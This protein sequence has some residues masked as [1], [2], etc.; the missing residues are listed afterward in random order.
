MNTPDISAANE[1]TKH[2]Q[3]YEY[4]HKAIVQ[5]RYKNGERLPSEVDLAKKFKTSRPTVARSLSD[6]HQSGL[7][8]RKVGSGTYVKF[9]GE[10]CG[11]KTFGLMVPGLGETEIFEPITAYM[12]YIAEKN[13]L[14]LL[15]G[16]SVSE[17][18]EA[19]K[20]HARRLAERFIQ[21]EV[22]GV[23]FA[24]LELT[25][26]KD[27]VNTRILQWFEE[28]HIPVVLLDRDVV[29]FPQRSRYDL[30]GIDNF[31]IGSVLT[32]HMIECGYERVE[33]LSRP[34][35]APTVDMRIIAFQQMLRHAG[36]EPNADSVRWAQPEDI[37]FI[38][39]ITSDACKKAFICANDATAAILMHTLDQLQ[40]NIPDEIGV[41][42]VDDIRYASHL[43]VPLTT[44]RQ[45]FEELA[46]V[47]V[48]TMLARI[49]SP[50][51]PV[52]STYLRGELVVRQSTM[53]TST[54]R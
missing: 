33:F 1:K 27:A 31:H 10:L 3:I 25:S 6:L 32:E 22:D 4:L 35:S 36:M 45:P 24:P 43:R 2:R 9:K 49:A 18:A 53:P 28:A 17:D 38:R 34:F 37:E 52:R 29:P 19:R 14:S 41:A 15:W 48:E 51:M 5:G 20:K 44:Y 7:I 54:S 50:A 23:F 30:V 46:N 21:Q 11:A 47:A 39:S 8:V 26:E 40:I 42:G 16:R 13:N 12:S